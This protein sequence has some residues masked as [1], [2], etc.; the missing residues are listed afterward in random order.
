MKALVAVRDQ[1][2]HFMLSGQHSEVNTAPICDH[3]K[4]RWLRSFLASRALPLSS[5]LHLLCRTE[6]WNVI[7]LFLP[8]EAK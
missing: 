8:G 4:E 6:Q 5:L 7:I 1:G 3:H 2:Q